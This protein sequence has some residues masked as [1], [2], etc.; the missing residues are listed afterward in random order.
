[1][2]TCKNCKEPSNG[3]YCSNCGQPT[4]IK[5]I[6]RRYI[7]NEIAN[8]LFVNRGMFYTIKN[9]LTNPGISIRHYITEDRSRFVKPISFIVVTSLIYTIV[10]Y[11]FPLGVENYVSQFGSMPD[12]LEET[13]QTVLDITTWTQKNSGYTNLFIGL[14][15]ALGI[16][17]FFRKAGYNVP[18]IYVLLCYVFGL[19]TLVDAVGSIFQ[20]ITHLNLLILLFVTETIYITWAVGQFFNEK[21]VT[22]YI[23]ALLSFFFGMLILSFLLGLVGVMTGIVIK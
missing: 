14:F 17:L 23:K 1:M 6:N 10:N 21:K 15:M 4:K 7:F 9:L 5:K 13:N 2:N 22:S 20:A 18:E 3:N 19:T 8:V 11:F 12:N 16:K